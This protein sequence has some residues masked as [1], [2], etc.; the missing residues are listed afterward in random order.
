MASMLLMMNGGAG[1]MP[2]LQRGANND[3]ANSVHCKREAHL[4][5]IIIINKYTQLTRV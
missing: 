2:P 3:D 1:M 4:I 5:N